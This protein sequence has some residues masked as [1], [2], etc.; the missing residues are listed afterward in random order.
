METK[1]NWL[2]INIGFPIFPIL[3]RG[4]IK[5]LMNVSVEHFTLQFHG[6]LFD[7]I[8]TS[9]LLFALAIMGV[10]IS[11]DLKLRSVPLDNEDKKEE[12]NGRA[13]N[14]MLL[15][16]FF[17]FFS[18]FNEALHVAHEDNNY[19]FAYYCMYICSILSAIYFI[20][21]AWKTQAEFNLASK[22]I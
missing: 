18:A 6:S 22:F 14:M 9:E 11:Q 3:L 16:G 4:F 1:N 7:V 10:I 15:A 12:R 5:I 2:I 13:R 17:L 8:H 20:P 19:P 21:Y